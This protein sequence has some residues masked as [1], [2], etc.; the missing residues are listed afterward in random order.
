MYSTKF[1]VKE[2]YPK[3]HAAIGTLL[4]G[5]GLLNKHGKLHGQTKVSQLIRRAKE[6]DYWFFI[7]QTLKPKDIAA[8]VE[9]IVIN[10]RND[11]A[12]KE[13]ALAQIRVAEA[14][15]SELHSNIVDMISKGADNIDILDYITKWEK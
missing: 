12:A 1:L 5:G 4:D 15:F 3:I 2:D 6:L 9:S 8:H 14:T 11:I 7:D 13:A 10:K